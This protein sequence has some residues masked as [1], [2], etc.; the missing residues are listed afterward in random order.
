MQRYFSD[1]PGCKEVRQQDPGPGCDLD[2][3]QAR[4]LGSSGVISFEGFVAMFRHVVLPV[5]DG[6][7]TQLGWD[8]ISG[9]P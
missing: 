8:A 4:E 6:L 7:G 1:A 3:V 5:L 9:I 2:W